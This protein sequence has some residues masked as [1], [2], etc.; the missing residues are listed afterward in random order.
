[1][2]I[3][4]SFK[5]KKGKHRTVH[6]R[7]ERLRSLKLKEKWDKEHNI[8]CLPKERNIR[9]KVKKEEKKEKIETPTLSTEVWKPEKGKKKSRD[10]GK[11]K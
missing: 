11:I 10:V 8:F 1:M 6:K 7:W 4:Q 2:S 3:H 9:L 5:R